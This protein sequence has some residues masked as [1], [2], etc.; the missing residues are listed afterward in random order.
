MKFVVSTSAILKQISGLIG[1]VPNN[2]MI[3]ILENFL[4]E[5]KKSRL[6]LTAS[7]LQTSIISSI[8][9]EADTDLSVCVPA[10]ML[11]DT[12]KNLPEQPVTFTVD[13]NSYSIEIISSNGR[14]KLTG[15]NASD[16]PKVPEL[17][18]ADDL[19]IP[20]DVLADAIGY[21]LFATSND[22]MKPAMNG[23][24]FQIRPEHIN[25]VSSDSHRLIR[26]RRTDLT[27][28]I[29]T[30][31]IVHKRALSILKNALPNQRDIITMSFNS[32]YI[33]FNFANYKM[34][35][36]LVD[37][38]FPDYENVIPLNNENVVSMNRQE[39]LACLKRVNIYSNRTTNQ[40][41]FK[42]TADE[43]RVSAEDI[44]FSNE[45]IERVSIEH[46]GEDIE[47]GFN[48]KFLIEMINNIHSDKVVF[49]LS[50]P[51]MAGL[52]LPSDFNDNEDILMLVM[53]IMLHNYV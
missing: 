14:Y 33:I 44:D 31:L 23:V 11:Q 4:L 52:L 46:D 36:R 7:D 38:R 25:F 28:K 6:I 18:K 10:K 17:S 24:F 45:A 3:P 12:L 49:K 29:E 30:S 26:Y 41:R 32:S 40:V 34:I 16:F 19:E 48:A 2:P 9:V 37:E 53:P 47:I 21:T 39:I 15:E 8:E 22:E 43:M 1:V 13:L 42:I 35:T 51:G 50:D 27:S 5:V 20:S